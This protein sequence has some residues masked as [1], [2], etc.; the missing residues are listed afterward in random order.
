MLSTVT[1]LVVASV[2]R[3]WAALRLWLM[4]E[5]RLALAVTVWSRY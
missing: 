5:L 4:S 1:K 3:R 2:N